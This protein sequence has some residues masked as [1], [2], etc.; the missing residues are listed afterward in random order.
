[1]CVNLV[2]KLTHIEKKNFKVRWFGP[3]IFFQRAVFKVRCHTSAKDHL[4]SGW[5]DFWR[6]TL[7]SQCHSQWNLVPLTVADIGPQNSAIVMNVRFQL[8]KNIYLSIY[9]DYKEQSCKIYCCFNQL[10]VW[11]RIFITVTKLQVIWL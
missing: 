1:M 9:L 6:G 10:T 8:L 5:W 4:I 11:N 7:K 2:P 3:T